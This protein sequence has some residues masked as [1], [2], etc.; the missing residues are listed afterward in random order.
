[1]GNGVAAVVEEAKSLSALFLP[2]PIEQHNM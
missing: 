1:M 2:E